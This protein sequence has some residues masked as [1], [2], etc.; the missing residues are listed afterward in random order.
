MK[1]RFINAIVDV[2]EY[3]DLLYSKTVKS[4]NTVGLS[5]CRILTLLIIRPE[6][7]FTQEVSA[8]SISDDNLGCDTL[9]KLHGSIFKWEAAAKSWLDMLV[10][11]GV[12]FLGT[13]VLQVKI[14]ILF[15][16]SVD[17]CKFLSCAIYAVQFWNVFISC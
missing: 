10:G 12:A 11:G 17:F 7:L 6:A 14:E 4:Q 5:F 8:F 13:K 1:Q 3:M 9:I 16:I 15:K 2:L